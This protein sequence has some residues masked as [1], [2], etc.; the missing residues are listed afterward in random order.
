MIELEELKESIRI[1][2]AE[3][4]M[5]KKV[6]LNWIDT[7]GELLHMRYINEKDI[8]YLAIEYGW[9]RRHTERMIDKA[10]DSL[11]PIPAGLA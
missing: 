11:P 2:R 7:A 3:T 9:S 6:I 5:V 8:K 4:D 1:A 10:V